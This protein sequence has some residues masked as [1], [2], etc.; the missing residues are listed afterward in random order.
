MKWIHCPVVISLL[1]LAAAT[2]ITVVNG[3]DQNADFQCQAIPGSISVAGAS[4][5]ESLLNAWAEAYTTA[6]ADEIVAASKD[7][8]FRIEG[9]GAS[10]GAQRVC[11]TAAASL[12]TG[13]DTDASNITDVDI[14]GLTRSL[15]SGEATV[16]EGSDYLYTCERSTRSL[17]QVRSVHVLY[18]SMC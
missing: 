18:L 17:I 2:K 11:G 1:F 10:Q 12:A 15:N 4:S 8:L 9:G 6:C 13:S 5:V 16:Q 7:T 14:A 3:Q